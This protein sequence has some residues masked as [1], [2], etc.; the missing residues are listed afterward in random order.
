MGARGGAGLPQGRLPGQKRGQGVTHRAGCQ[1]RGGDGGGWVVRGGIPTGQDAR[2]GELSMMPCIAFTPTANT[3]ASASHVSWLPAALLTVSLRH[4][5][6][7][8]TPRPAN[9]A[10][11]KYTTTLTQFEMGWIT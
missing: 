4:H 9:Y 7:F 10:T 11:Y 5:I 2:A 6:P 1:G 8:L 3:T